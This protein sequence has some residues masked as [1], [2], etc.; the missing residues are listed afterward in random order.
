[1]TTIAYDVRKG[2]IAADSREVWVDGGYNLCEKLFRIKSGPHKGH[3]VGTSGASSPG[4]V[5]VDWY[6]NPK[7]SEPPKIQ[8]EDEY[9]TCLVLTPEGAFTVDDHCRLVRCIEPRGA[10]GSG[11]PF[12]IGAM[13][14]GA[15]PKQ[16]VAIACRHSAYS[17]PPVVTMSLYRVA[18]AKGKRTA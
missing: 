7:K 15:T 3:I 2:V 10:I 18:G 12:A 11:A 4:I 16:A 9:F 1:M 8:F 17:G 14:M 6:A 5:F 13:D